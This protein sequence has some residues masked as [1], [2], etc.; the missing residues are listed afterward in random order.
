MINSYCDNLKDMFAQLVYYG[1]LKEEDGQCFSVTSSIEN[2]SFVLAA[3]ALV[4]GFM[5]SFVGKASSQYLRDE[6]EMERRIQEDVNKS[7][8]FSD[9]TS[10]TEDDN[11]EPTESGFDA[12]I[13]PVPVLF[14]DSYRWL[15]Q[16]NNQAPSHAQSQFANADIV[17]VEEPTACDAPEKTNTRSGPPKEQSNFSKWANTEAASSRGGRGR[18]D[19]SASSVSVSRDSVYGKK[20]KFDESDEENQS[21]GFELDDRKPAAVAD[22]STVGSQMESV[23]SGSALESLA[24]SYPSEA[25]SSHSMGIPQPPALS[26]SSLYP[27]TD[28]ISSESWDFSTTSSHLRNAPPPPSYRLSKKHNLKKPPP[29]LPLSE[30]STS[31]SHPIFED[32]DVD[33]GVSKSRTDLKKPP[34]QSSSSPSSPPA[35]NSTVTRSGGMFANMLELQQNFFQNALANDD[36]E[37]TVDYTSCTSTN[38]SLV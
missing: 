8:R 21:H 37:T 32:R 36:G 15:L 31:T 28:E 35:L 38:P 16:S 22:Y 29:G 34:P 12:K 27:S 1:I 6:S 13:H 23:G 4:L 25:L 33:D 11:N 18:S 19:D 9:E 20:L 14:T 5:G 10:R 2:G 3:A 7:S 17:L 30:T 26:R 24:Y